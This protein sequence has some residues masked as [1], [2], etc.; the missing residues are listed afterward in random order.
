[1]HQLVDLVT[2][3]QSTHVS[4]RSMKFQDTRSSPFSYIP[5]DVHAVDDKPI[6]GI[7]CTAQVY[8]GGSVSLALQ[9]S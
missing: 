8:I 6:G 9:K 4:V 2:F 7:T 3:T 1:M 5:K